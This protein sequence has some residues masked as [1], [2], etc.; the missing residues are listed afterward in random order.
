MSF[1]AWELSLTSLGS[2]PWRSRVPP[3]S[4]FHRLVTTTPLKSL[5]GLG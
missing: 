1:F 5:V 4:E 2:Y 3:F